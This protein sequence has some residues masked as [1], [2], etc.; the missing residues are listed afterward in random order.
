MRLAHYSYPRNPRGLPSTI[1][2]SQEMRLRELLKEHPGA[3]LRKLAQLMGGVVSH[4][5]IKTW[6]INLRL[7]YTRTHGRRTRLTPDMEQRL[8]AL[9]AERPS[10]HY[11]TYANELHIP[12]QTVTDWIIKRLGLPRR[13]P[14]KKF[15]LD[16]EKRL[17]SLVAER[18]LA[19]YPELGE[20]LELPWQT[21]R[22]W[23]IQ[24]GL[25][26]RDGRSGTHSTIVRK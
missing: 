20:A 14:R 24:V 21:V 5:T 22:R 13:G 26:H 17:R 25:Q 16:M 9:I 7:P 12:L 2:S 3:S 19:S 15:T 4:Q 18:P 8:R 1:T 23:V 10:A 11:K 6:C